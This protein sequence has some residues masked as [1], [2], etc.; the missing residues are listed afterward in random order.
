MS[1]DLIINLVILPAVKYNF[2]NQIQRDHFHYLVS[3]AVN[4]VSLSSTAAP[5]QPTDAS[6][7]KFSWN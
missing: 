1:I 6:H 5:A 2:L 3:S 4:N 7:I